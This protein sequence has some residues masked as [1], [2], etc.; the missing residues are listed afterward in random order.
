MKK[1]IIVSVLMAIVCGRIFAVQNSVA[2]SGREEKLNMAR[3]PFVLNCGQM[4]ADVL[5]YA[6]TFA[7]RVSVMRDSSWIY[8]LPRYAKATKAGMAAPLMAM[9]LSSEIIAPKI[10]AWVVLSESLVGAKKSTPAPKGESMARVSY[11]LGSDSTKWKQGLSTW[12]SMDMG[13]VYAGIN[14]TLAAHG[15]NVEK[16]FTVSPGADPAGIKLS[17]KG[18]RGMYIGKSGE[19]VI[20]TAAGAVSFTAP[21]AYQETLQGRTKIKISY[22]VDHAK[23]H[24]GF[25]I[26][27]YDKSIPLI[28][29]PLIASTYIGGSGT[30]GGRSIIEA[31]NGDIMITG[32]S[33]SSDYPTATGAYQA[34]NSG[35]Y[36]IV[37]SR[38]N[39]ELSSLIS[40]TYIGGIGRDEG[41]AVIE[42]D[43]GDI[44]VAGFTYS[45]DYPTTTGAYQ[46][47]NAG[48]YDM[49]VTRF[50]SDLSSLIASTHIGGSGADYGYSMIEAANGN[51][52]VGGYSN[53]SNYPAAAGGY[54]TSNAGDYDIVVARLD[55][56]L[57]SMISS[58]YI[59]GSGFDNGNSVAEADNGDII[60]AGYSIS[61]NYPA[62]M[63]CYQMSNAG[64]YDIVISRFNAALSSLK[65]STY[66]GGRDFDNGNSVIEAANGDIVVAGL[67]SS[68]NYPV[69]SGAYQRSNAGVHDIVISRFNAGL[70]SLA[71][72]TFIGGSGEDYGRSVIE[73]TNGYFIVAGR[74][75]STDYPVIAGAGG[76]RNSGAFDIVVSGLSASLSSL[77]ASTYIGGSLGDY[78]FSAIESANGDI[79]V[80]GYSFSA[81]YPVTTGAYHTSLTGSGDSVI[82]RINFEYRAPGRGG[83][84][85]IFLLLLN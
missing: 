6:Q 66:I 73:S 80:A 42:A 25:T 64:G 59:G 19:L 2:D 74:S 49:V 41:R 81:N 33:Y 11:F 72:S 57:S 78:G 18:G 28:I 55:S 40:S 24:Y 58:T 7:G 84:Q 47:S 22:C 50:N 56:A 65:A 48:G 30:D 23:Q 45:S 70:S 10:D 32:F 61:T 67:S 54:Q 1:I 83:I 21:V 62:V 68:P 31:D 3:V 12:Q 44:I 36:D 46:M 9:G 35:G 63:G 26:G 85:Y 29:D 16:I 38:F 69:T 13:E 14:L 37:V 53:S 17:I 27:L 43:N 8:S 60:I 71:A 82:T 51:I 5:S 4:P 77:T 34:S 20:K 79:I 15:N 75:G 52:V 76:T 39:A